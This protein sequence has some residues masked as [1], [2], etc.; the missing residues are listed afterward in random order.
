[1]SQWSG[2][3]ALVCALWFQCSPAL[4]CKAEP[5]M[6]LHVPC[7]HL[8]SQFVE[9]LSL[10]RFQSQQCIIIY[11]VHNNNESL[12]FSAA[13][14]CVFWSQCSLTLAWKVGT[15]IYATLSFVPCA[16]TSKVSWWRCFQW[17][18]SNLN[19]ASSFI[20]FIMRHWSGPAALVCAL[21]SQCS[22]TLV[23]KV[24]TH[25]YV[26]RHTPPHKWW[27]LLSLHQQYWWRTIDAISISWHSFWLTWLWWRQ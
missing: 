26:H 21:W 6:P 1:M 4:V 19:S 23:W 7:H 2:P 15:H 10:V 22:Q 8:Q 5:S 25:I 14:V 9:I 13:L 18:D 20:V 24:E 3:A 27:F 16:N 12:E 17:L 11:C